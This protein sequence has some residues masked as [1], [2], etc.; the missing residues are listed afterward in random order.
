MRGCNGTSGLLADLYELTMAAGYVQKRIDVRATFELF[1]R[2]LPAGRN[3]LVAAG[4]DQALEFLE[5]IH[6]STKDVSYICWL[7]AFRHVEG[8]FLEFLSNFRF[9]GDVWALPEGT[10][11]FPGEPLM[12]V[13]APIG[14]AQLVETSLLSILHLQ[15]LVAS[16]AARVVA[17]ADGRPVVEFGSRRAHGVEAGVLAARAAYIGGC[18]GTSNAYAGK[19]FGIPVYG[20]QAHS[21]IMAHQDESVAFTNFLDV[22]PDNAT[23]LVDTYDVRA[24]VRRIV[25]LGRKPYAIR[26]DSG[27]VLTDSRWSRAYLDASGWNDVKVF[28]SGDLDEYRIAALLRNG[29]CIDSFGVGTALVTSSDAPSLSIIYK[30]VEIE[31]GGE[32]RSALKLSEEKKTYPGRKQV[33]RFTNDDGTFRNDLIELERELAPDAEP[34]LIPVM[35]NGRRLSLVKRDPMAAVKS[36]QDHFLASVQRLPAHLF[37]L[38]DC[39]EP[40]PVRYGVH[41]EQLRDQTTQTISQQISAAS[42]QSHGRSRKMVL[43]E[44]DVQND[45][46]L[47]EG[48]LHVPGAEEIIPNIDHLVEACRSGH[49]LLISTADAHSVDDPE[50]GQWPPHCLKGTPGAELMPE[51]QAPNRLVV[52]NQLGIPLPEN[53]SSYQ[54]IVLEKNT[55]DVFD[56]PNTDA[57]F[58]HPDL[59]PLLGEPNLEFIVFGVATEY[60]VRV[61]VE[62][63]LRRGRRVT[64]VS[65]AIRALDAAQETRVLEDLRFRGV[66]VT[67][68][69]NVLAA[70]SEHT[71]E[72][73]HELADFRS[74]AS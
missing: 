66:R 39:K 1:V 33:F 3:Y 40:F 35:R 48:K 5:S 41:L 32:V 42:K 9:T 24:A 17:A 67:T 43:W 50:L 20:T 59:S 54:Q 46:M 29:A 57:L 61:E 63:L 53:L 37:S 60:C 19:R 4:L 71:Q 6:F 16:K 55:L 74:R 22:F 64:I 15:T 62:G 8:K 58:G 12:R 49:I 73:R 28:V 51:A 69:E 68:T 36:G 31:E 45:F 23:L 14:E 18:A 27:D 56:N 10:I 7:P 52:P 30:L 47:S 70:L 34:L 65:D 38:K 44:V 21:W 13:T 26:L 11:F 2:H 72:N 25:E